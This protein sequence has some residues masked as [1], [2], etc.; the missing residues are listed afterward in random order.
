MQARAWTPR[1]APRRAAVQHEA[2][3]RVWTIEE[4]RPEHDP[5]WQRVERYASYVVEEEPE[6]EAAAPEPEIYA[7]AQEIGAE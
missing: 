1:E 4:A 6:D 7:A 3:V 2:P 5:A